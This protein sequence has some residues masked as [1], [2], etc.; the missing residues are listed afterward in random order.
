MGLSEYTWT[1]EDTNTSYSGMYVTHDIEVSRNAIERQVNDQ[2]N[3]IKFGD[4]T[5]EYDGRKMNVRLG[6]TNKWARFYYDET[7]EDEF[8]DERFGKVIQYFLT[9]DKWKYHLDLHPE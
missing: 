1:K 8:E 9:P 6:T 4:H 5:L 7:F 3:E 2:E